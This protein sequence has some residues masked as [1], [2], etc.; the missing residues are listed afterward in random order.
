LPGKPRKLARRF[1]RK[2][3]RRAPRFLRAEVIKLKIVTVSREDFKKAPGNVKAVSRT[4]E[5][6]SYADLIL[7]SGVVFL[8]VIKLL[9][10]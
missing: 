2:Y 5:F 9:Q 1:I 8:V 10:F 7:N 6:T 4:G 3:W